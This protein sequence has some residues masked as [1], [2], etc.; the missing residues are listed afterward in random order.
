MRTCLLYFVFLFPLFAFCQNDSLMADPDFQVEFVAYWEVGDEYRYKVEKHDIRY[1][2]EETTKDD[3]TRYTALF[4][5]LDSTATSY[6]ISWKFEDY[7]LTGEGEELME[8]VLANPSEELASALQFEE[9]IFTTDEL[10]T[11]QQIENVDEIIRTLDV[12]IEQATAS[13]TKEYVDQP[14][15]LEKVKQALEVTYTAMRTQAYLENTMFVEI[16]H[17]L[18]PMGAA[19][20]PTD[21]LYYDD[22]FPNNFGGP[23]IKAEGRYYFDTLDVQNDYCHLKNYVEL[24][25]D[26]T[27]R[28]LKDYFA[29][30]GLDDGKILDV[31]NDSTYDI[32]ENN[33]YFYYYYPGIPIY[34]D[35]MRVVD[36]NLAGEKAKA[37]KRYILE[38]ID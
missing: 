18:N 38:W 5:V 19:F 2:G 28:M 9:V 14:E 20:S 35:Q 17:L 16:A 29:K 15:V 32:W 31:L 36:F 26:D 3:T 24:D 13:I 21:T 33:D 8:A 22:R 25:P 12:F 6:R 23:E 37:V 10:G 30:I 1:R 7:E 4:T 34:I 11:F 27:Q